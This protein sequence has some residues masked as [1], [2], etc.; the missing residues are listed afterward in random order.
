MIFRRAL[1]RKSW[2]SSCPAIVRIP[3]PQPFRER[4]ITRLANP[5]PAPAPRRPRSGT[6]PRQETLPC[7]RDPPVRS[8]VL[9]RDE[10]RQ[11][12][13]PD[14]PSHLPLWRLVPVMRIIKAPSHNG[15]HGRE[16][17]AGL[18]ATAAAPASARPPARPEVRGERN[19]GRWPDSETLPGHHQPVRRAQAPRYFTDLK[20]TGRYNQFLYINA[21][22]W[23][24]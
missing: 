9:P 7:P 14:H 23:R 1:A 17:L 24:T 8:T 3:V 5:Q 4:T 22:V 18:G 10:D 15:I 20:Y 6:R 21:G 13:S 19:S 11:P 16:L 12:W 2:L